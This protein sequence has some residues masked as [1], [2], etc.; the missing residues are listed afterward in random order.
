MGLSPRINRLRQ[1]AS[2]I[3]WLRWCSPTCQFCQCNRKWICCGI[4]TLLRFHER[5]WRID[6]L[7]FAVTKICGTKPWLV[8]SW[9]VECMKLKLQTKNGSWEDCRWY[10]RL[11]G[12]TLIL[13]DQYFTSGRWRVYSML[14]GTGFLVWDKW[15]S[16]QLVCLL[17]RA[18]QKR[19]ALGALLRVTPWQ[20]A[21]RS[22][23]TAWVP[24]HK[25]DFMKWCWEMEWMWVSYHFSVWR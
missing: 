5:C 17:F 25:L 3:V 18:W 6:F 16:P 22:F 8:L 11:L 9:P 14:T 21:L 10:F 1:T 2:V 12:C 15:N 24:L 23:W 7:W 4:S 20:L 19:W 13:L